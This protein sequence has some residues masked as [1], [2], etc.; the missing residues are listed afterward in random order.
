VDG[1]GIVAL[2]EALTCGACLL[3][4]AL[5]LDYNA[6]LEVGA[7]ALAKALKSGFCTRLSV[8]QVRLSELGKAGV[9]A[10]VKVLVA[11]ACPQHSRLSMSRSHLMW[12]F[13]NVV[14]SQTYQSEWYVLEEARSCVV[15][16]L[17]ARLSRL[18]VVIAQLQVGLPPYVSLR[19]V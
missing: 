15:S 19:E 1:K 11:G 5:G 7:V 13:E 6:V 9:G 16:G 18:A 14:E 4:V 8:L 10:L 3:L 12:H 17:V 2:A